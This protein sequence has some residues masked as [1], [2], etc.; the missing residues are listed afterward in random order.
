MAVKIQIVVFWVVTQCS[1]VLGYQ[2]H[3]KDGGSMDP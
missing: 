3:P 2:L 1:I